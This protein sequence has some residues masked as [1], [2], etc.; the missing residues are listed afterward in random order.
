MKEFL[1][2][3]TK[4]AQ[5]QPG[6]RL[7]A[8]VGSHARGTARPDSDID[9]LILADKPEEYLQETGWTDLFG[10]AERC[11]VEDW[12]KVTSLRAWFADG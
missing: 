12:G 8:L 7:L 4:W 2:L 5:N 6:I 1:D 10:K 3:A 9:L 11:Q